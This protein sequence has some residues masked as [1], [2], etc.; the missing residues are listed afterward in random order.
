MPQD[1]SDAFKGVT[2]EHVKL[3]SRGRVVIDNPEVAKSLGKLGAAKLPDLD[4]AAGNVI[5]C[6]NT[7]CSSPE[8]TDLLT[9][10]VS[11]RSIMK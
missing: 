8:L 10:V 9:R 3:D 1:F 6:G 4:Q 2:S 11:G 5:C 7:G